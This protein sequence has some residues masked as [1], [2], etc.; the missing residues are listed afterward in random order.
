MITLDSVPPFLP[1]DE[2]NAPFLERA[3][4]AL[5]SARPEA[6]PA[7]MHA[8]VSSYLRNRRRPYDYVASQPQHTAPQPAGAGSALS[9][10]DEAVLR[11]LLAPRASLPAL[12]DAP[13]LLDLASLA[14]A[15]NP[16]AV[17]EI[18][19]RALEPPPARSA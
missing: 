1:G 6:S 19:R 9:E 16:G 8:F 12:L 3:G 10:V 4:L 11:F 17:A 5:R 15:S 18:L 2:A 13:A 7:P 14:G